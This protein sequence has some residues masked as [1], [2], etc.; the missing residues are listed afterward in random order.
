MKLNDLDML[1]LLPEFMQNDDTNQV[2]ADSISE[3][4]RY[5]EPR[6]K[7]LSEWNNIDKLSDSELDNLAW[8]LNIP[9]YK[10]NVDLVT[11]RKIIIESDLVH[12]HLGTKYSVEEVVQSYFGTGDVLEWFEYEGEP[13]YFKIITDNTSLISI[14]IDKFFWLLNIVKRKSA[15]LEGLILQLKCKQQIFQAITYDD[16]TFETYTMRY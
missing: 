6:L 2:L 14:E 4:I 13:G 12:A 7:I 11:K 5:I 9:W 3:L 16:S 8:E 15:W 10:K 1:K